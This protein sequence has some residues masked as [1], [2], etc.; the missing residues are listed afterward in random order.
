MNKKIVQFFIVFFLF[1]ACSNNY[2]LQGSQNSSQENVVGIVKKEGGECKI[3][4][5]L[6]IV[7]GTSMSPLLRNGQEINLLENYYKCGNAIQKGDIVAYNYGGDK[8]PLIK[9]VSVI[10][11]DEV[12]IV[13]SKMSVNGEFLRNSV[14]QEYNFSKG[15]INMLKLYIKDKHIPEETYFLFGDN[16]S[17]STDSRKFG[18]VSANDFLGRFD[19]M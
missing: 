12:E 16:V 7:D 19:N 1:S 9:I 10:S 3:K 14:G 18:A 15:E 4:K 17:V 13:G 6:K 8:R 5:V 2:D 11:D